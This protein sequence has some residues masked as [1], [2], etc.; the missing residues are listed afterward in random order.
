MFSQRNNPY[1]ELLQNCTAI[2]QQKFYYLYVISRKLGIFFSL[3]LGINLQ[4]GKTYQKYSY[5][6]EENIRIGFGDK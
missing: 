5:K 3:N 1:C 2:I 6:N 4:L